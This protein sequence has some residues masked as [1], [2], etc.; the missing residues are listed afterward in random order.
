MWL[1]DFRPMRGKADALGL[2]EDA[3]RGIQDAVK[4]LYERLGSTARIF[5]PNSMA[6]FAQRYGYKGRAWCC[7]RGS[8]SAH[9]LLPSIAA[10]ALRT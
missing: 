10:P 9:A 1:Q 6:S 5:L 8:P 2:F 3:S 7:A 4:T